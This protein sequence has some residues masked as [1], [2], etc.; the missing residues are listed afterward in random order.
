[1]KVNFRSNDINIKFIIKRNFK[2][3]FIIVLNLIRLTH[4]LSQ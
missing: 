3:G 2:M 4:A 1:M